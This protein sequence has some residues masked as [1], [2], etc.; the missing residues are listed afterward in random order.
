MYQTG[1]GAGYGAIG[2]CLLI[3]F[4]IL[5]P[6]YTTLNKDKISAQRLKVDISQLQ[7]RINTYE[8]EI[9]N[10]RQKT[11]GGKNPQLLRQL[12]GKPEKLSELKS[13][14][15]LKEIEFKAINDS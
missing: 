5:Q 7:S 2:I 4:S 3:I 8:V 13:H 15:K 9:M 1:K 6:I 11:E 14:L 12:K 10:L